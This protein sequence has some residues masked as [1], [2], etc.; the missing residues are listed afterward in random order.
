MEISAQ[1]AKSKAATAQ[2]DEALYKAM[3]WRSIGPYRGGR[4]T[5]VT[6]IPDQPYTFYFGA[7]GGGVW[8]STDGGMNWNNI[9]DG[10][11][12]TGSVGAVAVSEWDPN[13]I[14]V[15]MGEAP[16][17]G[18]VSHG[19][20][21]YKSVDAGKTWTH[22]GLTNTRQISR[23]RVHPRDP[24]LVYVAALGH[25]FG[26]SDE[27]GVFRSKD[28]GATWEKVLFRS[29]K[30]GAIDLI[31]DPHNPRVLYAAIWEAWRTPYS[32]NSGGPDSGL[33][34]S[35][36]GG[37]NWT[38]ITR[39]PGLPSGVIGKIGV[40]AS[41]AQADRVWAIVEAQTGG[42]F[43]SENGGATWR[44]MNDDRSLRQRAWYYSRIYADPKSPD[45]V[46]VLNTGLYR[47][48]DGGR[49]YTSIRVPHGDNH[50]LWIDPDN[51]QRMINSNDGGANVSYNGGVTWT[52][53]NT[54]PTAQFY[55][56]IADNQ[57]PYWVYGA[58]QDNSTV[59]I[60]S[61]TTGF[62][63][64]SADWHPVG[65]GESGYIAPR[66]DNPN[67]VYAGSYGGH[68]TRWDFRTGQSRNISAW[69]E[70]PMGWGAK[71][72]KYRFQWTF[73]IVVSRFDP[74]VLY[75][76]AQVVFKSMN[77]GQSWTVISPDLT[78]ND[79]SKQGKSGGPITYDDTSVEYYCT[80]FSL[81]ESVYDPD[82]LWAGSDD[83]LV[84]L[85][86]DSGQSW[87]NITPKAMP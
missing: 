8:K 41:P 40:T 60:A 24:D 23:I 11:F 51:P 39:N 22:I 63:I 31:M 61:R 18:N 9:S 67:I 75:I 58:Q 1:Q 74:N 2:Y 13:V 5:A 82:T 79:K 80:I 44:K 54:Q 55:H 76:T 62:G 47:S 15:G 4:A 26:I 29:D 21:V 81:A 16:I 73:P 66:T 3:Q 43:R 83:G 53:Q 34:K 71:D 65:G 48:V 56:V 27:R 37:D 85:T 17:R 12:K 14:Y 30:A 57:F 70:N 59:R 84:H 72:L 78:T 49:T 19:D 64:D 86:R 36:D 87:Q 46:Y 52:P 10:F 20:G 35:T 38:E 6:G 77:E 32:L 25:V 50:D 28:G 33:F 45:G 42:V 7:T 68:I 69:P